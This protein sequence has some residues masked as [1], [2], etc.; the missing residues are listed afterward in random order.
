MKPHSLTLRLL[1]LASGALAP[2]AALALPPFEPI[3]TT[4]IDADAADRADGSLDGKISYSSYFVRPGITVRYINS[5]E[6]LRPVIIEVPNGDITIRGVIDVSARSNLSTRN[7]GPGGHPGGAAGLGVMTGTKGDGPRAGGGGGLPAGQGCAGGGG[8]HATA[9][10]RATSRSGTAPGIGGTVIA[11]RAITPASRGVG[12]S[13][14]GGGGGRLVSGVAPVSGGVG[15]G[16]GGAIL[17]SCPAGRI[18]IG[19]PVWSAWISTITNPRPDPAEC[20]IYANGANGGIA[21]GNGLSMHA[22]P[23][24]GGAGGVIELRSPRIEV[25]ANAVLS[26]RGGFGGGISSQ[27]Y[28][29]DP[30]AFSCGAHG[31]DGYI[32]F[33]SKSVLLDDASQRLAVQEWPFIYCLTHVR[34][35]FAQDVVFRPGRTLQVKEV[36]DG[37]ETLWTTVPRATSPYASPYLYGQTPGVEYWYKAE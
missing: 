21:Y 25:L 5:V 15:G 9:G 22:G 13:G 2:G 10:L 11:R 36:R 35:T 27:P 30:L 14:G 26:V 32:F 12:G 23:G 8:G 34:S 16:G 3:V 29:R 31:G 6:P 33:D 18:Q 20:G 4:T 24:G 19:D 1:L 7:P 17:F 28:D 37:I